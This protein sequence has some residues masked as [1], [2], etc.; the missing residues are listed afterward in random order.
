MPFDNIKTGRGGFYVEVVPAGDGLQDITVYYSEGGAAFIRGISR[1]QVEQTIETL[2]LAIGF[3]PR[4][5]VNLTISQPVKK[6]RAPKPK[7]RTVRK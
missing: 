6:G 7:K 1:A 4:I 5:D 3:R 2:Q